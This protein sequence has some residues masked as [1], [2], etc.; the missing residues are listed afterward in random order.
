MAR[1][2]VDI[3][4][5]FYKELSYVSGLKTCG[6]LLF[7]VGMTA[8]DDDSVLVGPGDMAK[9]FEQVF[10]RLQQITAAAGTDFEHMAKITIFVT[11][12]DHAYADSSQWRRHFSGCPVSSLV[13]VADD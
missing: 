5:D 4:I 7:N 8:R 3:D 9:Q 2:N 12:I 10:L 1:E 6:A 13:E 11:D